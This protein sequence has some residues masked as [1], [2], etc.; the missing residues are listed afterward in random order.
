MGNVTRGGTI[1]SDRT[2]RVGAATSFA[3][4][5]LALLASPAQAQ[6]GAN[7]IDKSMPAPTANAAP[8]NEKASPDIVDLG[9]LAGGTL[10]KVLA[11]PIED[12][13]S[14]TLRGKHDADIYRA[15]SPQVVLVLADTPEGTMSGSGSYLGNNRILTNF[16]VIKGA[17]KVG[18]I[19]KPK[20]EGDQPDIKT[21]RIARV[22][23]TDPTVDLALLQFSDAPPDLKSIAM[24][25]EADIQVGADVHAIGHPIG[26]T[27]TYTKGIISQYRRDYEWKGG[28]KDILHKAN[29]IQTQ[30]PIS[31]G[32]SGGP[33][34]TDDGKLLGVNSFQKTQGEN[35]NFAVSIL[36]VQKF[37]SLPDSP[38]PQAS[39][40]PCEMVKLYEGREQKNTA[41][42]VQYDTTC[43]G[44]A[45]FSLVKPDDT[46]QPIYILID[47]NGD[48]R[49][50]IRIEDR[51][52]DG[53][54]DI[55]YHDVDFDGV[56]DLVGFHPDGKITPT[57]F[58]KYSV[59]AKY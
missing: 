58:V 56:V 28:D 1:W 43:R 2:C 14:L 44:K 33:L 55:S 3:L 57:R 39:K 22:L 21:V 45:D 41:Q 17:N 52:R 15:V 29:V 37:L 40:K 19:F 4:L 26:Q 7:Y 38:P 35:L 32:N 46:S 30:T 6:D 13:G 34:L 53:R 31:P 20:T 47:D 18:V 25:S 48:G 50:D 36:D 11:S 42:L 49:P 5:S 27:W 23:K 10:K 16:H 51:D 8:L 9:G 12:R 59:M 54:W 24:A